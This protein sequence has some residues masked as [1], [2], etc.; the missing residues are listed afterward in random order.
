[1]FRDILI[2]SLKTKPY[3]NIVFLLY[4]QITIAFSV[5]SIAMVETWLIICKVKELMKS[6]LIFLDSYSLFVSQLCVI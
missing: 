2:S 4:L 1:M 6:Q 5:F 3:L